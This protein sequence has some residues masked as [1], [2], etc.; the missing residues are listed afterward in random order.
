MKAAILIAASML[1]SG[2]SS[3]GW[4]GTPLIEEEIGCSS[5]SK[6]L[7]IEINR[8]ATQVQDDLENLIIRHEGFRNQLYPDGGGLAIGYGRNLSYNPLSH[9]EAVY[10][11]RN[12]ITRITESL[13]R[14]HES[15]SQL[16]NAR[17]AVL[18]S[19]GY[20]MGLES[21]SEFTEMWKAIDQKRYNKAA[22]EIIFSKYCSQVGNR[23]IELADM[24][25]TGKYK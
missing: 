19:M 4:T 17:R 11:L 23:C 8:D 20:N 18:I 14:S 25:A 21:L 16:D 24:M 1:A 10:L 3:L 22:S 5:D 7:C 9:D 13:T 2:C 6:I 15:F 12:D